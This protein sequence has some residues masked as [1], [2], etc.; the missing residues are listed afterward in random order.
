MKVLF[1]APQCD[2]AIWVELTPQKGYYHLI[3]EVR[4]SR[5]GVATNSLK[6]KEIQEIPSRLVPYLLELEPYLICAVNYFLSKDHHLDERISFLIETY[7]DWGLENV[8]MST[9]CQWYEL[10]R[11]RNFLERIFRTIL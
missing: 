3:Q 9:I 2:C 8:S 10:P 11:N 5:L 4:R 1:K 7:P 6:A